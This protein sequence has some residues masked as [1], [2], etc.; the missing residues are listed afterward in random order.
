[1]NYKDFPYIIY[2][3]KE[4][5]AFQRQGKD[6]GKIVKK[7]GRKTVAYIVLNDKMIEE[8]NFRRIAVQ[9]S[10]EYNIIYVNEEELK[11]LQTEEDINLFPLLHEIGHIHYSHTDAGKNQN[12]IRRERRNAILE[13]TVE[14]IEKEADA[15]AAKYIGLENAVLALQKLKTERMM[16]DLKRNKQNSPLAKLS[17][18]EYDNRIAIIE[19]LTK[20]K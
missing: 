10:E 6:V 20:L 5:G 12:D 4:L 9:R 16:F 8:R 17:L 1:M 18:K 2:L 14:R 13:G 15:F 11:D 7:E 3:D 19:S